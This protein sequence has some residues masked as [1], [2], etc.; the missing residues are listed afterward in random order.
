MFWPQLTLV[1]EV[2]QISQ[3]W[4]T[5]SLINR[6]LLFEEGPWKE[7]NMTIAWELYFQSQGLAP[8]AWCGTD[9]CTRTQPQVIV[10]GTGRKSTGETEA[11]TEGR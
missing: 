11:R 7:E 8:H 6:Q 2:L 10:T 1:S 9:G 4:E 3:G 5:T